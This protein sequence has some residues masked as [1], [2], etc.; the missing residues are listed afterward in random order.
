MGKTSIDLHWDILRPGRTRQNMVEKLLS[1]RVDYENRWGLNTAGTLFMMLA[2]P[3]FTKYTTTPHATL[4]RLI[5]LALLLDTH[6]E[7]IKDTERLLEMAGLRTAGWITAQWLHLLTGNT[8]AAE[9]SARLRPGPVRRWWLRNWLRRDWSSRLLEKPWAIQLGFTLPA[10]D[11]WKGAAQATRIA[12]KCR[13]ESL[14]ALETL[15]TQLG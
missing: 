6:P 2:H 15:E 8:V 7:A 14:K 13:K 9:L 12:Q 10:H 3:V 5:D 1:D 11:K 4:V